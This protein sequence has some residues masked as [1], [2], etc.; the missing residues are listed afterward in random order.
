M[1]VDLVGSETRAASH[2]FFRGSG[3]LVLGGGHR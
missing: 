3:V 2:I 1:D